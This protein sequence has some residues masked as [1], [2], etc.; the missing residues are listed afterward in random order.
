MTTIEDF[1]VGND[2]VESCK[3]YP[4]EPN[5]APENQSLEDELLFWD[6]LFS[7]ASS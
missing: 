1:K 2:T 7:E 3:L 5:I 6:G 4:P